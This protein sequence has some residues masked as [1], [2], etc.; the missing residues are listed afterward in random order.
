MD[1]GNLIKALEIELEI[2]KKF[3]EVEDEKT[4]VIIEGN[5]EKLDAILNVEQGFNMKVQNI[6]KTRIAAVKNLGLEKKTLPDIIDMSEGGQ[7]ETLS[8]LFNELNNHISAIKRINAYNTKL[9]KSRLEIIAAV[10]SLYIDPETGT[11]VKRAGSSPGEA[12]IYGKDAK[13][14][15]QT[16]SFERAVVRKKL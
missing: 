15:S 12:A 4:A 8:R 3:A 11:K 5:I 7:K 14:T 16:G 9:V 1:F 10:N 13:I 6:E 2:Y